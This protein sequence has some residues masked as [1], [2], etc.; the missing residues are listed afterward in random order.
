M[1]YEKNQYSEGISICGLIISGAFIFWGMSTLIRP[2]AAWFGLWWLGLIWIGIGL[3]ILAGQIRSLTNRSKL[4]NVVKAEFM[5]NP[6]ATMEEIS[7]STGITE[8]DAR[9]II[10]DLKAN[11]EL[12]G[13]FSCETG[14][15]EQ[16]YIAPPQKILITE[17]TPQPEMGKYCPSCGT[18]FTKEGVVYCAYCG[19]K[20]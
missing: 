9:A 16:T 1:K 11:G 19:A 13:I 10:L 6:N 3:S 14:K 2:K 20:I 17:K 12:V 8:K 7:R 18:P 4:R 5:Q 15:M